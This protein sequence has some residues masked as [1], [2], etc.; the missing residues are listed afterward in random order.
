MD[1]RLVKIKR[2]VTAGR[3]D[4]TLK[5][6]AEC[7]GDGLT[8]RDVIESIVSAQFL[9][10]K[11]SVSPW[12]KGMREWIYIIDSFNFEGVPIYSKGVIRRISDHGEEFYILISGKR[13]VASD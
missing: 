13:S 12:R 8:R 11:K 7:I 1:R 4:F 5:A 3:Y 2:L 9:R 10:V 6:D